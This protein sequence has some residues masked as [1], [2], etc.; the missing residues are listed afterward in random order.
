MFPVNEKYS[1]MSPDQLN[2]LI[3]ALKYHIFKPQNLRDWG[4]EPAIDPI[5]PLVYIQ[6]RNHQFKTGKGRNEIIQYV[7][8]KGWPGFH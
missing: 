8:L 3:A 4:S 1:V 6:A 2:V 7:V 5:N